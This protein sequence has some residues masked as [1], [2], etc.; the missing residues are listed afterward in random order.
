M[1]LTMDITGDALGFAHKMLMA[2]HTENLN[3]V[4]M[5]ATTELIKAHY[6]AWNAAHPNKDGFPRTNMGAQLANATHGELELDGF[7]AVVSHV[8]ARMT[9][10]GSAGLPGGVITPG[11]NI[12]TYSGKP[13]RYLTKAV[14]ARA[15]G[16]RAAEFN[17][18]FRMTSEGPMLVEAP[19]TNIKKARGKGAKGYQAV[20]TNYGQP[21]YKLLRS[22]RI[23]G[24]KSSIPTKEQFEAAWKETFDDII[25][26]TY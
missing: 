8:A 25:A 12:S 20:S 22:A 5:R 11:K 2:I 13:T 16:H 4:L 17:L 15:Y 18:V 7:R 26:S 19:S 21:M 10:Y 6:I 1:N 24:D 23:E 9:Y 14:S 3:P